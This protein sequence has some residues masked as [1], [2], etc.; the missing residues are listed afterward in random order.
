MLNSFNIINDVSLQTYQDK[1]N[2]GET[3]PGIY[4]PDLK[5]NMRNSTKVCF[6]SLSV[7]GKGEL[8]YFWGHLCNNLKEFIW[9]SQMLFYTWSPALILYTH[10]AGRPRNL[11]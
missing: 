6:F 5:Y 9:F 4:I 3:N 8:S 11:I 1:R 7:L 2:I 10:T